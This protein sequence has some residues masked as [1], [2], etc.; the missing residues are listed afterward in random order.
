MSK[1]GS[2]NGSFLGNFIYDQ[3]LRRRPHL[4]SDLCRAVDFSFIKAALKDFPVD[5]RGAGRRFRLHCPGE[6]HTGERPGPGAPARVGPAP[7][8]GVDG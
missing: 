4:L 8:P 6:D 5:S 7:A 1:A 3:L 2:A